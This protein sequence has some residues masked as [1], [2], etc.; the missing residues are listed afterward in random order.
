MCCLWKNNISICSTPEPPN[1]F[2]P[3]GCNEPTY[4]YSEQP[5]FDIVR[6]VKVDTNRNTDWGGL[7]EQ[8]NL[9]EDAAY[10]FCKTY[11]FYDLSMDRSSYG[12]RK[13][14]LT[15]CEKIYLHWFML[16]VLRM[17]K[18][19]IRIETEWFE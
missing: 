17:V 5:P 18:K 10:E 4:I 12:N 8:E 15:F 11:M 7:D 1:I 3:W 14:Q 9:G 6:G 2:F 16:P 13:I 19:Q